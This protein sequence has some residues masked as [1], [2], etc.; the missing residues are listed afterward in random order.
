MRIILPVRSLSRFMK[1][2][3][4]TALKLVFRRGSF[5][6]YSQFGEDAIVASLVRGRK[7]G[8]Y[9]DVGAY[10]PHLYSNT[11]AFYRL[12]WRG[13]VIDPNPRLKRLFSIF[14]PR[15]T[16]VLGGVG[17]RGLRRY[18]MHEDGAYNG[19]SGQEIASPLIGV[20]DVMVEPLGDI[21]RRYHITRIDLLSIDTEGMEEEVL[22]TY[23]W[24]ILPDIIIIEGQQDAPAAALLVERGY[25]LAACSGL[26]LVFRR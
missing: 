22:G 7:D 19:F 13:L 2:I 8:V 18:H 21:L 3:I 24:A 16:F 9:V 10:H 20:R 14:R 1:D 26:S 11:Y 6:S 5:I 25:T 23:D 4:K 15:D 12:G 17:Q